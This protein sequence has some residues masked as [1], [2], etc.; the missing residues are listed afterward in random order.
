MG[1]NAPQP[2]CPRLDHSTLWNR[3]VLQCDWRSQVPSGAL[4]LAT[5]IDQGAH[6]SDPDFRFVYRWNS[7]RRLDRQIIRD[8]YRRYFSVFWNMGAFLHDYAGRHICNYN[9]NQIQKC[10]HF[11][12]MFWILYFLALHSGENVQ[13][14]VHVRTM[15]YFTCNFAHMAP[16]ITIRNKALRYSLG[17]SYGCQRGSHK[18]HDTNGCRIANIINFITI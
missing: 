3:P 18:L 16:L 7:A 11:S 8:I 17:I 5:G 2:I 12:K 6:L 14:H 10:H 1:S 15:G 9:S 13:S 4:E